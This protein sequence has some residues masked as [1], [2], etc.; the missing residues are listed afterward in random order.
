MKKTILSG[1]IAGVILFILSVA[2]LYLTVWLFPSLARQYFNPAFNVQEKRAMIFFVHPFVIS[3]CLAWF[4]NRFKGVLSGSF[5]SK[6]VEFGLI[7]VVIA[8]FPTMWLIYS[9]ISV[10]FAMVVTW[11]LF[12][13]LQGLIAGLVFEK[14][15][16]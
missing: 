14:T 1:L 15:N 7:Y 2:S 16:P 5:F 10:S 11:M 8:T 6:G 9:A 12:G 13:F 4:W 3:L